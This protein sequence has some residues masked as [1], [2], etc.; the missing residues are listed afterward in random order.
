[1][2]EALL[3]NLVQQ[4]Q[5]SRHAGFAI[6]PGIVKNN[7]DFLGLGR[8][9]VGITS[10]PNFEP[11]ARLCAVGGSSSRGF[12][13]VPQKGDEV[14]V[15]FAENDLGSAYILG[16]LWSTMNTPP[17]SVPT[18]FLIK[19]VI[20]TGST[21]AV[22]HEVEFDDA[23]QSVSIKT[24]T[25][26]KITLDPKKIE[27]TNLAGTVTITLDNTSQAVKITAVNK[28]ELQALQ[29][30]L[31]GTKIDLTAAKVSINSTGPCSV[32]GLPIKL[33]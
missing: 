29:I 10:R 12:V 5:G 13:W 24:S 17:L 11:W 9:Q 32:T 25:S 7:L 15:A 2:A 33:N 14:L 23:L 4:G 27:L 21:Q 31:K 30:E 26:Q 6:A 18:D 8:V 1:M 22:G 28:I 19:K 16:G 3:D 20:K